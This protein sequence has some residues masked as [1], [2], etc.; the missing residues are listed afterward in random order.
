MLTDDSLGVAQSTFTS[1][2]DDFLVNVFLPQLEDTLRDLSNQTTGE[3]DAFSQDPQWPA[4]AQ[5]PVMKGTASFYSLIT[6][7]C[8]MLD[9]IP[10]DQAFSQLIMDL[11]TAYYEKCFEFFKGI[12]CISREILTQC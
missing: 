9:S 10:H 3:L 6:A 8:R 2:L 7:I 4:V 12:W 11:L 5:R 1:F